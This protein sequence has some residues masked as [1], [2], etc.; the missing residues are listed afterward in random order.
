MK[1]PPR[2]AP[3]RSGPLRD[4]DA[5]APAARRCSSLGLAGA[6]LGEAEFRRF[7]ELIE[8]ELGIK[9]PPSK[10]TLLQSRFQRRLRALNLGDYRQYCDYVFSPEGLESE[11]PH[12]YDAVTTNTTHFFR[13]PHHFEIL[14]G[15][16]LPELSARLGRQTLKVWSAGCS[17][18]QEP[19]TLAMVLEEYAKAHAGFDYAIL[20]TDISTKILEHALRGV[21][22]MDAAK[23]VP[24][25]LMTRYMLKSKDP[26]KGLVRMAPEVR[27]HIRFRR[28]NFME[29][30]R[31]NSPRHVIF[32]RNVVI[33]FDRPTQQRLFTKFCDHLIPGGYLFIGHSES[34]SGMDLPL[35]QVVPTV[36]RR[37]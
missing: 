6:E 10:K 13:E 9:M 11:R 23:D 27:R 36:F 17:S 7:S 4:Q 29:E 20:A 33:Y 37:R 3:S 8:S 18:G 32:C 2:P 5:D 24:R 21:Y 15:R 26:A 19:Y 14:T 30:F 34:L 1:Q 35:V 22:T 12:L 25:A 16:V 31:L 28:L